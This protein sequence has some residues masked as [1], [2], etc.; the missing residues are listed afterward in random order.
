M[1][2]ISNVWNSNR[3]VSIETPRKG[4]STEDTLRV[5]LA[6]RR[7][8]I[9]TS[10]NGRKYRPISPISFSVSPS[11]PIVYDNNKKYDCD[12]VFDPISTKV[13]SAIPQV[14]SRWNEQPS[15]NKITFEWK[16]KIYQLLRKNETKVSQSQTYHKVY[17]LEKEY[18]DITSPNCICIKAEEWKE[19]SFF[20][21]K[22]Y[23]ENL[24][25]NGEFYL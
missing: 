9:P 2:S 24:P 16:K 3:P 18:K 8:N 21:I 20:Y 25:Y 7:P 10:P 23:D 17:I 11:D 13:I 6:I 22:I 12:S 5:P 14:L 15:L 4:V 19:I 1:Q